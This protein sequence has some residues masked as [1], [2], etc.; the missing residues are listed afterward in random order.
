MMRLMWQNSDHRHLRTIKQVAAKWERE[1]T[2]RPFSLFIDPLGTGEQLWIIRWWRFFLRLAAVVCL[3]SAAAF[4]ANSQ[5]TLLAR[6]T[7]PVTAPGYKLRTLNGFK[8]TQLGL[9]AFDGEV[10]RPIPFQ[11]DEKRDGRYVYAHGDIASTDIDEGALDADDELAFI[12]ADAGPRLQPM[13]LP[14]GVKA[15]V[16]LEIVDPRDGGRG[17]VYLLAFAGPVPRSTV[18]Y[19][20]YHLESNEI[21]SS[22]YLIGYQPDAPISTAKLI[23]KPEFGGSGVSVADRQK[24]R[25][26]GD[27]FWNLMRLER[28]ENDFRAKVLGYIDGPVRVIRRTKNWNRLVWK[29]PTPS[30]ELTSVYWKTGMEFPLTIDLPFKISTFF[31]RVA[32]RIYIDTPP[33]VLGRRY[34][35]DANPQGVDIDGVMSE[36]ER[37]LDP[38]S[39]AWQVVAGSRPEHPEGWFSRNIYDKEKIPASMRLYYYDDVKRL[40]PPERYPGCYGCLGFEFIDL[41]KL[42]AGKF[43]IDIHMYPVVNYQPGDEQRLLQIVDYPLQIKTRLIPQN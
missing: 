43:S 18:D 28:N 32:M 20:Q 3:V 41:D 37:N 11:I 4:A 25:I 21:E 24:V 16:E 42:P 7:D 23:V 22:D 36:A 34:Y 26:E 31:R 19:V 17:Y 5:V 39:F 35:S 10:L 9:F 30:V 29:I 27:L 40:D 6:T 15:G 33:H 12:C 8:I 14:P 38:S 1:S 13:L 2:E